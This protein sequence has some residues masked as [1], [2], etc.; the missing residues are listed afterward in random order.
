MKFYSSLLSHYSRKARILLDLYEAD[1][2]FCDVGNVAEGDMKS[3]ADNPL[4]KVPVLVDG[5]NWIIESDHIAGYIVSKFDPA[6]RY[7]FNPASLFHLNARAVLNGLMGDEVK[8]ILA[9]RA[10]VP[11]E[12]YTFFDDA[13]EAIRNGLSWLETHADSFN[14]NEPGYTEFH[15]T[16]AWEH[17]SHYELVPLPYPKL[18][19]I[20]EAVLKNKTIAKTSP[21]VLKPKTTGN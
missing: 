14:A 12:K 10:G 2:E 5:A 20:V 15:L 21:F 19:K 8:I 13:L 16:C 3:F 6:D 4:M 7:R 18:K 17:I 1:Y 9:R 11:T